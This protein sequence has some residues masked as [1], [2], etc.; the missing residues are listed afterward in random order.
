MDK[1]F[2]KLVP[3]APRSLSVQASHCGF[4][5][6]AFLELLLVC[7]VNRTKKIVCGKE[8]RLERGQQGIEN[9]CGVSVQVSPLPPPMCDFGLSLHLFELHF[10]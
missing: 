4:T 5:C 3:I 6:E 10:P 8:N 7:S 9:K 2:Y 1:Q